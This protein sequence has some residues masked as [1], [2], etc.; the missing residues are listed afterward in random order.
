MPSRPIAKGTSTSAKTST[1]GASSGSSTKEWARL[2][3]RL[4]RHQNRSDQE[5]IATKRH[6]IHKMFPIHSDLLCFL[7]APFCGHLISAKLCVAEGQFS[8]GA[9]YGEIPQ[10][11][12]P[13]G[14]ERS[15]KP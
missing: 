8:R 11:E 9:K 4:F 6:K 7:G 13:T 1:A 12:P 14:R 3:A 15:C 2:R 10:E 5:G